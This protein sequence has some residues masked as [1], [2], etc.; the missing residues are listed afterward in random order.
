MVF[1]YDVIKPINLCWTWPG[2][3][4][5][6]YLQGVGNREY[7]HVRPLQ[8]L[9]NTHGVW[10]KIW[11]VCLYTTIYPNSVFKSTPIPRAVLRKVMFIA[12]ITIY[13]FNWHSN[14]NVQFYYCQFS[15]PREWLQ[16]R[17][18]LWGPLFPM[19][20]Q[21]MKYFKG[22]HGMVRYLVY[23]CFIVDVL[24]MRLLEWYVC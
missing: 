1:S 21:W 20:H 22:W 19:R 23:T 6:V 10:S 12:F 5:P 16:I 17:L 3:H 18:I 24:E 4:L 13:L 8:K 14:N 11:Y 2:T 15:F 9:V 7:M